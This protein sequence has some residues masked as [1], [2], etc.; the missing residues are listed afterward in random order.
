MNARTGS[1]PWDL[2]GRAK[3]PEEYKTW[4]EKR[5]RE[6]AKEQDMTRKPDVWEWALF[7]WPVTIALAGLLIWWI[8]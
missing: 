3:T 7:I 2:S 6:Q 4:L 8:W 1:L 5:A